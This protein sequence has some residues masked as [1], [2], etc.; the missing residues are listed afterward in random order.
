MSRFSKTLIALL[1][2]GAATSAAA[3]E[4]YPGIGREATPAEVKA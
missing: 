1:L 3:W 2:A 4:R